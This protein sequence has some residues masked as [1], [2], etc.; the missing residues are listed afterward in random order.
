MWRAMVRSPSRCG[1]SDFGWLKRRSRHASGAEARRK[2]QAAKSRGLIQKVT[3]AFCSG[4]LAEGDAAVPAFFIEVERQVYYGGGLIFLGRESKT[5][6]GKEGIGRDF[7][8]EVG[9]C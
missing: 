7:V 5:I 4:L 3:N 2:F 8:V 1:R 6:A 9:D